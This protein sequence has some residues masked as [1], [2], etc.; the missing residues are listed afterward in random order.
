MLTVIC[1]R[2]ERERDRHAIGSTG[3]GWN[4]RVKSSCCWLV[5]VFDAMSQ[6]SNQMERRSFRVKELALLNYSVRFCTE[7]CYF[8]V[9][10][11]LLIT[12]HFTCTT[13]WREVFLLCNSFACSFDKQ[14]HKWAGAVASSSSSWS[15]VSSF[16]F[17]N[18]VRLDSNSLDLFQCLSNF[19]KKWQA[20]HWGATHASPGQGVIVDVRMAHTPLRIKRPVSHATS[21]WVKDS[22]YCLIIVPKSLVW[23][24]VPTL[25]SRSVP[26]LK[27][28]GTN[29]KTRS[30]SMEEQSTDAFILVQENIATPPVV[31]S[32]HSDYS[33]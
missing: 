12:G 31:L 14:N 29:V 30:S 6:L 4:E 17:Q 21:A 19:L 9:S 10:N 26:V 28:I 7:R 25:S 33:F 22:E 13:T 5:L 1:M 2:K 23:T 20:T 27:G 3:S 8:L 32:F 18:Q 15:L 11:V 24:W 16:H